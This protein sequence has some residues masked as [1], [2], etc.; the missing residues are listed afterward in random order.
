M[1]R[2][3]QTNTPATSARGHAPTFW[4]D[5][6]IAQAPLVSMKAK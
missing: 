3:V 2:F 4:L 1:Y 6:R 5:E